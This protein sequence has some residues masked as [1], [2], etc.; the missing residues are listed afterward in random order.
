MQRE[1]NFIY[2][3]NK[4]VAV[5]YG[6]DIMSYVYHSLGKKYNVSDKTC[7]KIYR[8]DLSRLTNSLHVLHM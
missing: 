6:M 7:A 5:C 1:T 2:L 8:T 3:R 4:Q